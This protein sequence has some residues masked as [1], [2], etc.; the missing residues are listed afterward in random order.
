MIGKE[1][2][3]TWQERDFRSVMA[4]VRVCVGSSCTVGSGAVFRGSCGGV[5]KRLFRPHVEN[6]EQRSAVGFRLD[7]YWHHRQRGGGACVRRVLVYR[8]EWSTVPRILRRCPEETIQAARRKRGT[9]LSSWLSSG[10]LLA[11]SAE[12]KNIV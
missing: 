6:A 7:V 3:S 9:A 2:Y 10:R 5:R 11:S 8:G 4:A 1:K 12:K